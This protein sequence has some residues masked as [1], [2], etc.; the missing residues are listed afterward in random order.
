M[1]GAERKS[2]REERNDGALVLGLNAAL[3]G[4]L[5]SVVAVS[6]HLITLTAELA[7]FLASQKSRLCPTFGKILSE[8]ARTVSGRP[9]CSSPDSLGG[10][11]ELFACA[12]G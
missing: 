5:T 11:K 10:L 2:Q 6:S 12:H 1:L 3:V 7:Y 9:W 4:L 8:R